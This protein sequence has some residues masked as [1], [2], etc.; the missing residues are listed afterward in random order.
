MLAAPPAPPAA[1]AAAAAEGQRWERPCGA[2]AAPS[3][4]A[5]TGP[6]RQLSLPFVLCN[7]RGCRPT[8][9]VK[10]QP[11]PSR[12]EA[13]AAHGAEGQ[14]QQQQPFPMCAVWP[15][16]EA[17]LASL[18]LLSVYPV[19]PRSGGFPPR[20]AR[21]QLGGQRSSAG[22]K[23]RAGRGG[24]LCLPR[25]GPSAALAQRRCQQ[26]VLCVGAVWREP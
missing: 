23:G 6:G 7:R 24:R 15:E 2:A 9:Y 16:G 22:V 26:D 20:R 8:D 4:H 17:G 1:A 10:G 18:L 11:R 5:H 25:P 12:E 13:G 3:P 19:G 14:R 21:G